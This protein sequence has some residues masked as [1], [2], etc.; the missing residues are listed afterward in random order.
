MQ[1]RKRIMFSVVMNLCTLVGEFDMEEGNARK[2]ENALDGLLD[3]L[4]LPGLKGIAVAQLRK[5]MME[6]MFED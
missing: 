1:T 3:E 2:M 4:Q 6:L 5:I